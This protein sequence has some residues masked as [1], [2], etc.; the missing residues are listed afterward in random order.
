MADSTSNH[1]LSMSD[2]NPVLLGRHRSEHGRRDVGSDKS[3]IDGTG[4]ARPAGLQNNFPGTA[5][6]TGDFI[7]KQT[8]EQTVTPQGSGDCSG[9]SSSFPPTPSPSA[10]TTRPSSTPSGVFFNG[11]SG[12]CNSSGVGQMPS[13]V[14]GCQM[15]Q[16]GCNPGWCGPMMNLPV[17]G[18]ANHPALPVSAYMPNNLSP[19]GPMN[20]GGMQQ[21]LLPPHMS[22]V[23]QQQSPQQQQQQLPQML[24]QQ[25]QLNMQLQATHHQLQQ[26]QPQQLLDLQMQ[27]QQQ[28]QQLHMPP[29][30][31][32]MNVP[33]MILQQQQHQQHQQQKKTEHHKARPTKQLREQQEQQQSKG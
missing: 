9:G 32:G 26:Q 16:A 23:L 6:A 13:S 12:Q 19:T 4:R 21:Q 25:Q 30:P 15:N 22:D 24:Q 28:P 3:N 11:S 27:C 2:H 31:Q 7:H 29:S 1:A 14:G 8:F 17:S 18:G 5:G 10:A 33:S 20:F